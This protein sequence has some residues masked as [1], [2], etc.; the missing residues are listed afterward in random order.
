MKNFFEIS[1][2]LVAAVFPLTLRLYEP[3]EH[4]NE[5]KPMKRAGS[6]TKSG[7]KR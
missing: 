7:E 2:Q 3:D 5:V 4:G 1:F 6:V